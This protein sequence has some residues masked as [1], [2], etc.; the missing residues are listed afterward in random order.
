MGP[1]YPIPPLPTDSRAMATRG[2]TLIV[3]TD[4]RVPSRIGF[5]GESAV[6]LLPREESGSRLSPPA[7]APSAFLA[8]IPFQHRRRGVRP[9][10]G[11]GVKAASPLAARRCRRY[12]AE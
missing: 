4:Q 5:E 12:K 10:V 2:S 6:P 3:R 9:F 11:N 1:I 7:D 8:S